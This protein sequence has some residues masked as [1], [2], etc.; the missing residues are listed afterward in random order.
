[1][2]AKKALSHLLLLLGV[3]TLAVLVID[4]PNRVGERHANGDCAGVT[5]EICL[6]FAFTPP[7]SPEEQLAAK[8]APVV[9]LPELDQPCRPGGSSFAPIAVDTLLTNPEVA[10]RSIHGLEDVVYGPAAGD[11]WEAGHS[12]F[13]QSYLDLPG[14]PLRPGCRYER[15]GLRFGANSPAVAYARVTSQEETHGL[16]LQYWLFYY[17]NDWNNKHEADWELIQLYFD[18]EDAVAALDVGPASIGLSQHRSGSLAAWSD[19]RLAREGDH[20][21]VYVARGSHA[22][23]FGPGIYLGRGE[24]GRGLGCD[25]ASHS[26]RRV[27][28]EPRL[29]PRRVSGPDDPYAWLAFKGYWGEV[30]KGTEGSTAPVTK[31]TWLKPYNWQEG[32]QTHSISLPAKGILGPDP[33]R[34]FCNVVAFGSEFVL[35]LYRD[36]PAVSAVLLAATSLGVFA[37]LASTRYLPVRAMPLRARRRIGQIM[38][39]A[40]DLYLR[41]LHVFLTLGLLAFPVGLASAQ[42]YDALGGIALLSTDVGLPYAEISTRV[43]IALVFNG[44]GFGLTALVVMAATIVV[45][46][47]MEKDEPVDALTALLEVAAHLP[48]LVISKLIAAFAIGGLCLSIV[49]IPFGLRQASRW[50]LSGHAVLLEGK[51]ATKALRSSAD[52]IS[53]SRWHALITLLLLAMV[54]LLT[55]PA[56]GIVLLW[57]VKSLSPV[58]VGLL[59]AVLHALLVPY[60]AIALTLL[61]FDLDSRRSETTRRQT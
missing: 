16:I 54:A 10:L 38:T 42:A 26:S 6:P 8:H 2:T 9:Y 11:L 36:L 49:G 24:D 1:L 4:A 29:L 58:Y 43:A 46:G 14:N 50:S 57:F 44:L 41:R 51:P 61:Y 48:R 18:A 37:S 5:P 7:L 15:D 34:A 17:F 47:R 25:D 30:G 33:A 35:P 12:T 32:L 21:L 31:Q 40:A 52:L 23:Y 59:T 55:A 22:N 60:L 28:L 27:P 56:V 3:A 53:V 19:D 13:F 39:A 20:P 45:I